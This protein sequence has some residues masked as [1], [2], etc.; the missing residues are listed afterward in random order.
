[1]LVDFPTE[2]LDLTNRVALKE[3][4]KETIYD[5]IAVDNHYGGLGGGHYT[6]TAKNFFDGQ[7]YE[8]N[9]M[10]AMLPLLCS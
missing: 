7:W 10:W 2:G 8:Y 3:K 6:A 4:D 1:M 5:L 9:G